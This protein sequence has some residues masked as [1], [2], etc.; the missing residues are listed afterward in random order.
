MTGSVH[1]RSRRRSLRSLAITSVA[2]ALCVAALPA[3]RVKGASPAG[4][5]NLRYAYDL[6]SITSLD[7]AKSGNTCDGNVWQFVYGNLIDVD[8]NGKLSPGLLESWDLSGKTL[9]LKL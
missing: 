7:P 9:T 6:E 4:N 5:R 2:A 3:P 1:N 8:N